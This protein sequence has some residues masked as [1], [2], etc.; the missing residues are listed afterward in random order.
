MADY[1][2]ENQV[3]RAGRVEVCFR[4]T[5]V[6][7]CDT[8][9][10]NVGA[11]VVCRQLGFSPYGAVATYNAFPQSTLMATLQNVNCSGSESNLLQ[12]GYMVGPAGTCRGN[13][14][15]GA[16]CQGQWHF[17]MNNIL[18]LPFPLSLLLPLLLT[19]SDRAV[20]AGNCQTGSVRLANNT[21]TPNTNEGRVELCVNNAWGTIC[22][23]LFGRKDAEVVCRSL[24]GY[25]SECTERWGG[26]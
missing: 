8:S 21:L 10:D 13:Q 1:Y 25:Q 19:S 15:A 22:D 17:K 14:D 18:S 9:W 20:V 4:G 12:C 6:T 7:V 26:G 16:I 2:Y 24:G 3:L 11:S 23:D 5:R